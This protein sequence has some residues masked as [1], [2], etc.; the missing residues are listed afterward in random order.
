MEG[1][2][3]I[4]PE[5]K[6]HKLFLIAITRARYGIHEN[7]NFLL[8]ICIYLM[9]FRNQASH[10]F[11]FELESVGMSEKMPKTKIGD[12]FLLKFG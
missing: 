6:S 3:R 4:R 7:T 12:Q 9:K 8:E 2:S 10:L 1:L 11:P 5:S